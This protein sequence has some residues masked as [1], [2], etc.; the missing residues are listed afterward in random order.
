MG[1]VS[2]DVLRRL[3]EQGHLTRE[4]LVR[5]GEEGDWLPVDA[6]PELRRAAAKAKPREQPRHDGAWGPP[7]QQPT[8]TAAA[9][10]R[11]T[12][13]RSAVDPEPAEDSEKVARWRS[14]VAKFAWGLC[15]GAFLGFGGGVLVGWLQFSPEETEMIRSRVPASKELTALTEEAAQSFEGFVAEQVRRIRSFANR[16]YDWM[17]PD[18]HHG[19]FQIE[20]YGEVLRDCRGHDSLLRPAIGEIRMKWR[21]QIAYDDR[22]GE[23]FITQLWRDLRI[24]CSYRDGQWH[25]DSD[26]EKMLGIKDQL[27][28]E[29]LSNQPEE[30]A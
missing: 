16:D 25:A 19:S 18:G 4:A 30:G 14:S 28:R 2:F 17:E 27:R 26:V 1:P 12:S 10:G 5:E 11:S 20:F 23:S 13:R 15:L 8:A 29:A 21:R 24:E 7:S 9:V 22:I 3:A 6:L